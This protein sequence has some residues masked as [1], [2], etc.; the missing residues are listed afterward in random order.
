M[1]KKLIIGLGILILVIGLVI[2]GLYYF[3]SNSKG[4]DYDK[5]LEV[6]QADNTYLVIE[7]NPKL[8]LSLD[9]TGKVIEVFQLNDDA[10]IFTNN[11]LKGL[12]V[13]SAI[14]KIVDTAT[15]NGYLTDNKQLSISILDKGNEDYLSQAKTIIE[16]KGINVVE[17]VLQ[18]N[19]Q[20][21]IKD[22]IS[23]ATYN[24]VVGGTID[25]FGNA[26]NG[27]VQQFDMPGIVNDEGICA[28]EGTG[29][30]HPE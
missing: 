22:N 3:K 2:G 16:D 19:E 8:M 24:W 7:I 20:N 6:N 12:D 1:K 27:D 9:K 4:K 30:I 23:E 15:N 17:V 25:K 21:N 18:V 26:C 28:Y 10:S 14:I 13:E 29:T 11:D 5:Q